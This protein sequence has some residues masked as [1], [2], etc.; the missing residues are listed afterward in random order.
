M[1]LFSFLVR[2]FNAMSKPLLHMKYFQYRGSNIVYIF[3]SL[4]SRIYKVFFIMCDYVI[5]PTPYGKLLIPKSGYASNRVLTLMTDLVEPQW[6]FEFESMIKNARC[7]IDVG[8]ASD[9]FYS[10]KACKLN[11]NIIV[12]AVEPLSTEYCWLMNN[13]VLNSLQ[14]N[15]KVLKKALGSYKGTVKIDGEIVECTTLD[16]LVQ[17]HH[18][19]QVDIIKIDVEGLGYEVITEGTITIKRYKPAVFFEVHSIKE[20]KAL[21]LLRTLGYNIIEKPGDMYIA[22]PNTIKAK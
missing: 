8:A 15:V 9:G 19:Q 10:L 3:F 20:R 17:E 13:V 16:E 21:E 12:I 5:V 7:M 18:V 14:S 22:L 4:F 11:P 2:I 1:G 6:K